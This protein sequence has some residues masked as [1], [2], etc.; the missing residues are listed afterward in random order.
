MYMYIYKRLMSVP[1]ERETQCSESHSKYC[2]VLF[3]NCNQNIGYYLILLVE[4]YFVLI[5]G[6][7]KYR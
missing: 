3:F 5:N 6:Y 7:A 2:I 1:K 4:N